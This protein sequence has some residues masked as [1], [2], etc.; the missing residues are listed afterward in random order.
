MVAATPRHRPALESRCRNAATTSAV[1]E[2]T[3]SREV[4]E[5]AVTL[6]CR[7]SAAVGRIGGASRARSA[8]RGP[9]GRKVSGSIEE[10]AK[11]TNLLALNAPSKP[12]AGGKRA[13]R[14]FRGGLVAA[15]QEHCRSDAAGGPQ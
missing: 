13:A 14:L 11:Q 8:A 1:G 10:I 7:M 12:R 5:A 6:Y 4:V 2:I 3:Q 9:S 15:N